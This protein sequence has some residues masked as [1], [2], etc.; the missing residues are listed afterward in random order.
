[1]DKNT[2]ADYLKAAEIMAMCGKK[3]VKYTVHFL[4][5][6]GVCEEGFIE[7]DDSAD[8]AIKGRKKNIDPEFVALLN[9]AHDVLNQA[10][11]DELVKLFRIEYGVQKDRFYRWMDGK[12]GISEELKRKLIPELQASINAKIRAEETAKRIF[13]SKDKEIPENT[14]S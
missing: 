6:A 4:E 2:K 3:Y 11:F 10:S 9:E 1:M 14:E 7:V 13:K 12:S 5:K 8:N